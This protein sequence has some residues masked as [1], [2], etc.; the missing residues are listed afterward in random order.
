MIRLAVLLALMAALGGMLAFEIGKAP[1]D[2]D[3]QAQAANLAP[4]VPAPTP[5]A[6]VVDRQE[7]VGDVLARPLL[8]PNRRPP[9]PARPAPADATPDS[10]PRV[11]GVIIHSGRKSVIFAPS[12]AGKAIVAQEGG[13]VGAYL[14]EAIAPGQ[15]RLSGPGG[16]RLI[17]PRFSSSPPVQ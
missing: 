5:A 1:E 2:G 11:A 16:T 8:N 6:P 15:V 14:V 3:V 10:L 13:Q 7:L 12:G 4:P 17:R 9:E